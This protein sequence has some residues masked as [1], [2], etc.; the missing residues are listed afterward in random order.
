MELIVFL[1]VT[2]LFA[3]LGAEMAKTRNR[4][5]TTWAIVCGL[6]GLI[7]VIIL[8]LIGKAESA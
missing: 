1:I 6:T 8:A 7:G 5:S 3:W 2:G 4:D